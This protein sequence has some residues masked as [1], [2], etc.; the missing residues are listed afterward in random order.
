MADTTN[1]KVDSANLVQISSAG[2]AAV[3]QR[4]S[5]VGDNSPSLCPIDGKECK[6]KP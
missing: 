3:L 1:E 5:R 6:A 2:L 4:R